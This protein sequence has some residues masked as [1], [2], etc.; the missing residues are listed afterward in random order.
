MEISGFEKLTLTDYPGCIASIVFTQ[1]CNFKCPFCHNSDLLKFK[2]G[3]Y[4][5]TEILH[6]LNKR[7]NMLDGVVITGGEPTMQKDLIS[8][9]EKI[10]KLGL[11]IKLDT[12]GAR[13]E[14]LKQLIELK[15]IDYIA[16]DIKS[17][18]NNYALVSGGCV[19][20]KKVN[21]SVNLIKKSGIEFEF[22]TTIIKNFHNFNAISKICEYLGNDVKYYLQNFEDNSNVL[23]KNLESFS[24]NEL[25]ELLNKLK[26][27]FPNVIIRGI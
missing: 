12:N 27:R 11:K 14:V 4:S 9:L 8:F 24:K 21:E 3:L 1:G 18:R 6:Y 23:N 17:E 26:E 13:P 16:M 2:D 7:K 15:L 19:N 20:L 5:E 25:I 22:R 10:K